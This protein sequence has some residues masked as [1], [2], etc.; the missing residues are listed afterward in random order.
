MNLTYAVWLTVSSGVA[1]LVAYLAWQ[2]RQ[3]APIAPA[4][5]VLMMSLAFWSLTYAISWIVPSEAT[6]V[7][8]LKLTYVGAVSAPVAFFVAVLYFVNRYSWLTE[9]VYV[10]LMVIPVLTIFLL[11]TDP[12][13]HLFFGDYPLMGR[14]SIYNGGP[15]FYVNLVYLYGLLMVGS[16]LLIRAHVHSSQFYQRQTRIMLAGAL[17]PWLTNFF[18]FIG[19]HPAGRLD[20]TPVAFTGTGLLFA[21]GIFGYRMMDL[22][23]FSRDVL[24]ENMDDAILVVDTDWRV[25]DINP[26]ALELADP[27]LDTPIGK[28]LGDV[29]SRWRHIYPNFSDVDGRVEVKLDRP[30]FSNLD[31]RITALKDRQDHMAGKLV[32]WRDI[33]AQKQT[34]EKLRIFFHAVEQNPTAI[35]ITDPNGRIEYVNP[36]M[37]QLTGYR[38]EELRGRTPQVFQSGETQNGLYANLW[39]A[40]QAGRVWEGEILNRKKNGQLYWVHEMI[41]PVLDDGG[42]VTHFVAMQEDITQRKH[43]ESELRNLN[44]RLQGKLTEIEALHD[45]L[46]EEAIRDGLTRLFNR[47]YMEE[48]LEREISRGERDPKPISVVMMDVDWFKSINDRFGHQAGDAVLQTLGTMLLEN[49]RISDIACRYG[50]DEMVVVMPGATQEVAVARAEEWRAAFS[51]MEFTFGDAKIKTTLSMGVASF[52][53]QAKNPIQLLTASD[54]ALYWAKS[55]RNQVRLYDPVTMAGGHYRADDIR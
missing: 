36:Q 44:I 54:K 3:T 55:N 40:I 29:F 1:I 15:W 18:M 21:Y 43:A 2:R 37:V 5:F 49:T 11:W 16:I 7:V 28:P 31:L 24:V 19:Q 14:G 32:T 22:I 13:H 48:T 33:T 6:A 38:L 42:K 9:R 23:P 50:G 4:L 20:L 35:V 51:M 26:K 39:D 30:P 10:L 45:Q 46:R 52:P 34:E 12:W 53:D 47:R 41:A 27:G 17:L 8:W 25:V